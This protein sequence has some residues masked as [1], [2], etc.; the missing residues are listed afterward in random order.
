MAL[1]TAR[2]LGT[3]NGFEIPLS[4]AASQTSTLG[5]NL[6][7]L[8]YIYI[9]IEKTVAAVLIA[10]CANIVAIIDGVISADAPLAPNK[11]NDSSGDPPKSSG[12]FNNLKNAQLWFTDKAT[13]AQPGIIVAIISRIFCV[14][15]N[16]ASGLAGN[17]CALLIAVEALIITIVNW[18]NQKRR[19]RVRN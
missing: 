12:V 4:E 17:L 6:R 7:F 9:Y 5:S 2:P 3:K 8:R 11:I 10:I 16:V 15:T 19:R 14:A 18:F 13:T 1:L